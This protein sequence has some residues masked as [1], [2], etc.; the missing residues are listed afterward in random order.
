MVFHTKFIFVFILFCLSFVAFAQIEKPIAEDSIELMNLDLGKEFESNKSNNKL[1]RFLHKIIVNQSNEVD[2]SLLVSYRNFEQ[3]EGKTI[4]H[5]YVQT[6][7]PFGYSLLDSTQI[8]TKFI[9]KAGNTLHI[10]TK[11]FA[12]RN[13]LLVEEGERFDSLL[14]KE[15]ER[16]IRATR[17]IREIQIDYQLIEGS[18][19]LVDLYIRTLDSW[20]LFPQFSYSKSRLGFGLR[21]R[22]F[23]G[24]GHSFDNY[25]RQNFDNGKKQFQT[26]YTIPNFRK[27][28]VSFSIGY[29]INEDEEYVKSIS[30]ERNFFSPFTRWAGGVYVGQRAYQDSV[31][32][33]NEIVV[34]DFKYNLTDV[35]G[36][37]SVPIT[38]F[39]SFLN[40]DFTRLIISGRF[41][42]VNYQKRPNREFDPER[43]YSDQIFF[44][45]K[46]GIAER[47]YVQDKFIRNYNIIEDIPVG[48]AY[49]ITSGVQFKNERNRFYLAGNVKKGNYYPFGYLGFELQYGSFFVKNSSEESVFKL[50]VNYFTRLITMNNW[51]FRAFLSSDLIIGNNRVDSKGDRL[52][53]NENDPLGIKGFNSFDVFGTKKLLTNLQIQSYSPYRLLGFRLSP[54]LTSTFGLISDA[55]QD[56]FSGKLYT[57]VGLGLLLSNDYFV[58]SNFRI[59][60]SWYNSIPGQGNNLF[61]LNTDQIFDYGMMDFGTGKPRLIEYNPYIVN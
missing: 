20:T 38:R 59:S 58:F 35:W 42:N 12:V 21:E 26:R 34:H 14:I 43:F 19:N 7:D 39:P 4:R 3:A 46:V 29:A 2:S 57:R 32:W 49:G 6:H 17:F 30:L 55:T 13:Y 48:I 36:G 28:F 9:E 5:I 47:R 10:D 27:T 1:L 44:L 11:D 23:L 53:L 54:I 18:P 8:P 22:N 50:N 15:S 61:K 37:Y 33:Q 51:R 25:Y 16:L 52:T 31:R 41:F 40:S 56:L 45:G 60:F 24:F